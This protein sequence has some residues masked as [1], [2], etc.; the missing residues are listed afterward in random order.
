MG[1]D[2]SNKLLAMFISGEGDIT[3]RGHADSLQNIAISGS[4]V[5][6]ENLYAFKKYL[7]FYSF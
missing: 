7:E 5:N 3:I 2:G 6:D 1:S 4:K